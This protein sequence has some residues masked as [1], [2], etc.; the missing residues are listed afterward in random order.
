MEENNKT[1]MVTDYI[2][3]PLPRKN[4]SEA[5]PFIHYSLRNAFLGAEE[6]LKDAIEGQV[7]V[8]EVKIVETLLN[9]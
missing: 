9:K 2:G 8:I 6:E 4:S 5:N 3:N 1:Y 7:S